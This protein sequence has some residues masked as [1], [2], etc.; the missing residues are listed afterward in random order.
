MS[1]ITIPPL[2]W[3]ENEKNA[4]VPTTAKYFDGQYYRIVAG[5]HHFHAERGAAV[6]LGARRNTIEE[7]KADAEADYQANM[8]RLLKIQ[9]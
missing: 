4:L 3:R 6:W 8:K 1:N 7:A 5:V 2:T 9:D